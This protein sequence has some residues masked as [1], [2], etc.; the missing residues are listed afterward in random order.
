MES[1]T[2]GG[3]EA[4]GAWLNGRR[5]TA[6]PCT[7]GRKLL[8]FGDQSQRTEAAEVSDGSIV[9]HN[10]AHAQCCAFSNGNDP[11]SHDSIFKEVRL[12]TTVRV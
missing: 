8:P 9:Q 4:L 3:R 7:G 11:D 5:G 6:F 12:G 1:F 2:I 10:G